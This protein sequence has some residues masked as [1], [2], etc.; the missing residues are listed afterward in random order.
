MLSA[1]ARHLPP[2]LRRH[3]LVTPGTLPNWHRRLVGWQ[4]RQ[5]AVEPGRPPLTEEIAALIQRLATENPTWGYVRIPGELRRLGHR[6]APATIR[7]VLRR[8]GLP[9][10]PQRAS[11]QTWRSFLRAQAHSLLACAFMHVETVFLERLYVFF[12]MEIKTRRVHVLGVSARPTGVWVA[13]LARNLLMDL[14]ERAGC[15]RFLNRDR[16]SKFTAAFDAAF[17]RN[18]TANISTPPQSP[19]AN[20]FANDGY[21]QP[22]P[23]APTASSSPANDTCVRSSP[24]TPS[25]ATP[26]GPTAASTY[27]PQ[28]TTRTSSPYLL[29][30]SG[31]NRCSVDCSTSTTPRH[32][33]RLTIDRERP[34][35]Q[36]DRNNDTLQVCLARS[37]SGTA[38]RRS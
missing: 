26:G 32:P 16:D 5:R 38:L 24:P 19:R 23:N 34:A 8:T 2:V 15:F 33:D 35:Q 13:Q 37:S 18:G 17:P 29:A 4:W 22:A 14:K 11:Q 27:V 7:R 10:A 30:R 31:A 1:L 3:R 36:P 25:T 20:A 21:A 6:V 9:P 28:T 12:V